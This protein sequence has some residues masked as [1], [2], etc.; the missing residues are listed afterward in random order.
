MH[1]LIIAAI[2]VVLAAGGYYKFFSQPAQQ[3]VVETTATD[4]EVEA[5]AAEGADVPATEEAAS[6][7]ATVL[8]PA[9]FDAIEVIA[10]LDASALDDETKTALKDAV[11]AA[12][13]DPTLVQGVIDQVKA[14]LGM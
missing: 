11:T 3:A 8:D 1:N 4:V 9:T 6:D 7:I 5:T 10:L 12:A 14:A 13:S 2:V